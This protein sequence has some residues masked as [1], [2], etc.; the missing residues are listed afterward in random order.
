MVSSD[1]SSEEEE[2][3]PIFT[4]KSN[5]D[6]LRTLEL[7]RSK[8]QQIYQKDAKFYDSDEENTLEGANI[9]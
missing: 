3:S 2:E 6:F 9:Y 1:S 4:V 8:N 7:L 5:Q